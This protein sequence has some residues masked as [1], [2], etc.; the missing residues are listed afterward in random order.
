M[1]INLVSDLHLEFAPMT[2]PGG[3]VLILSGDIAEARAVLRDFHTTRA[4]PYEPGNLRYY[5]FFWHECAKY[6]R[7]F[8][9]M[10]NH[11]H[12]RGRFDQTLDNLKSAMP[13]NVTVLENEAVEHEGVMFMGATLWTNCNNADSLTLYHLK[14]MM[15]DYKV[16][17]NF[18]KDKGLYHKLVPEYTFRTH[19]NT[20]SYFRK[21]L[22]ENRDRQFVIMTH[23]APSFKSVP[24]HFVHDT[25]MNGGYASDLSEF[26]LDNENIRVW[27]H[28]HMHDPVDYMIGDT[29]VVSNPRGYVGYERHST[30]FDPAFSFEVN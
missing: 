9:V 29:R 27:T 1:K 24:E 19:T 5:D 30:V 14:H 15:N 3:D 26:I 2:L 25:L 18:Y 17:Q 22:S 21:V 20:L 28:G 23:H 12:Y 13:P 4:E 16:I 6:N 11:E 10:G 8:Y 7:V